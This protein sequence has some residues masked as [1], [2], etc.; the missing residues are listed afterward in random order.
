MRSGSRD[1]PG[2]R[3]SYVLQQEPGTGLGGYFVSFERRISALDGA[4]TFHSPQDLDVVTA[5]TDVVAS[6]DAEGLQSWTFSTRPAGSSIGTVIA[7]GTSPVDNTLLGQFDPTLLLN[8]LHELILT[9]TDALGQ[10]VSGKVAVSVEGQMKIGHFTL[11]FIDL[12]VPVSGLDIEVIRTYDSRQR[13]SQGDFGQGWTLDIKQGSYRNNRPPGD[14][15]MIP[16]IQGPWGLP[17]SFVQETKSHLT[18]V[19]LSDQE[20]YRFRLVLQNPSTVIGGCFA[21]A[22]FEW[23]DG[24]LP[25]TTLEILG[26]TQVFAVNGSDEVVVPDTQE[27]FVPQRRQADHP[28][29]SDIP[30]RPRRRCDPPRRPQRQFPRNH[31]RRHHAFLG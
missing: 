31:P 16:D 29:R 15:W 9:G 18:T 17:C 22:A 2:G 27:P 8:G 19:R 1:A 4:V 14:G 28:R 11:S 26:N 7:T 13:H 23:V 10:T 20:I 12:A 24:P 25:G 3:W 6:I 5:P 21:E 30:P